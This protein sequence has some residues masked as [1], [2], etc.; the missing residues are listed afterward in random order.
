VA[1]VKR[2]DFAGSSFAFTVHEDD[3]RWE[4]QPGKTEPLRTILRAS[5]L[6]VSPVTWPAYL[7]TLAKNGLMMNTNHDPI[8][9]TS[10]RRCSLGLLVASGRNDA[11]VVADELEEVHGFTAYARLLME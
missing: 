3:E 1:K 4:L 7:Q 11:V 9:D 8:A 2:G 5:L 10:R 6:D